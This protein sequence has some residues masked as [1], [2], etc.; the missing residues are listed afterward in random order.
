MK[1]KIFNFLDKNF[2]HIWAFFI[3]FDFAM[4]GYDFRAAF[5]GSPW[6]NAILGLCMV[7][8]GLTV[9]GSYKRHYEQK[10]EKAGRKWV[11]D[12]WKESNNRMK[13]IFP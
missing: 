5:S 9:L 1:D 8:Y 7:F 2:G 4:A 6:W 11:F 3:V 12:K 13:D 10:A